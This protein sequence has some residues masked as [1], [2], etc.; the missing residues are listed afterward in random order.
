VATLRSRAP[1]SAIASTPNAISAIPRAMRSPT[2]L[3]SVLTIR[4][5]AR[6]GSLTSIGR[7]TDAAAAASTAPAPAISHPVV[8]RSPR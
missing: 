4:H 6:S 7:I 2:G 3:G 5:A 1:G 8:R